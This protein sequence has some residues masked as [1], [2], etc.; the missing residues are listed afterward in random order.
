[1]FAECTIEEARKK[2]PGIPDRLLEPLYGHIEHGC[3]TGGFLQAVLSNDLQESFGRADDESR[4]A[5]PSLVTFLCNYA[6]APCWG[7]PDKVKAWQ[8]KR[9]E[10]EA[11]ERKE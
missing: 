1:M 3:P 4:F 7:S 6:P 2:F 8:T 5:I 9:L 10:T 11:A